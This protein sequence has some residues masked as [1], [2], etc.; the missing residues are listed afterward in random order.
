MSFDVD[1]GHSSARGP[2]EVNED[3]G[4]AVRAAPPDEARG[5]VAVVADGVSS[6]G[7]G[8]EAAQTTVMGL[9]AD[10]FATPETWEPTVVLD[11]LIAAQNAWLAGH[12]RRR[13]GGSGG[14]ALTTLTA[15]ALHGQTWTLAHVGDSRAW[16][17]RED[18][19][20]QA[21]AA[22]AQLTQD[23]AFEHPD[24]RSRLTRA[25]G[26][27]DAVRVDYLQGELRIGDCFVL[28]TDGVHRALKPAQLGQLVRAQHAATAQDASAAIVQAALAAGTRDN[29]TALVIRV[30][31][32]DARQLD[33]E[34]AHGRRLPPPG[35]LKVGDVLDGY[36]V[37]AVVVDNGVHRIV[38]A[39]DGA[40]RSLVAM[41]TL[42]PSRAGDPEERAM[43][44]HEAWLGQRVTAS[45][46]RGFVRVHE[47]RADA[48][49]LYTVFDWHPGRTIEQ[50]LRTGSGGARPPVAAVVAAAIECC[51][52]LGRLHRLGVIHRD[53]KPGNLHL[54]DD[55]QWRILDLGVA[56]SGRES[57]AQ[58]ELHAGTPSYMNPEQW[59][60]T[61]PD[62]GSDLFALGVTL[63]QWLTGRLPYGEI[64][65][66]QTA[67][68][69]RDPV[70]A[71]RIR[72]E[73]PIWLDHL[74]AKAV[75][76]DPAQRFETAEE[77]RLALERGAARPIAAPAATPLARR[78]PLAL[79]QA[80]L[81]LSLL[82]NALLV[83]WLLFLPR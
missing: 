81:V 8:L 29:A 14:A 64:E 41:K 43:L 27:D 11:R 32:L 17:W 54:G 66:Y 37:T 62:A 23:H 71:S 58:R 9:L 19:A 1:I 2:R 69:R 72:P 45:D 80:G 50:A 55:G 74:L 83:V 15:L 67:R 42:H 13:D 48:S 6:G 10:Y 22:A 52:A 30:T 26:L 56:L 59:Q 61:L 44:A 3:F 73:V 35:L 16:L 49:A 38:Q 4:G 82:L 28:T 75:A 5:L 51:R 77:M 18:G 40:S 63:Y 33:D 34:L 20:D 47:R 57:A 31:G 24:L 12:N 36:T 70:P 7:G 46:S 68:Y 25:I 76:R 65:P 79:W 39:R 53:I 21:D 78:D 60:G